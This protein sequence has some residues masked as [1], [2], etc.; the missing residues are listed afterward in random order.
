MMGFLRAPMPG[1]R[2]S[3]VLFV[4][5]AAAHAYS[6]RTLYGQA[7][8][9]PEAAVVRVAEGLAQRGHRVVVAQSARHWP[10]RSAGGVQYVPFRY[11]EGAPRVGADAVVVVR[12]HKVLKRLRRAHPAARFL[13]W[14]HESPGRSARDLGRAASGAGAAVVT[15]SDHHR[16]AVRSFVEASGRGPLTS[17]LARL[18]SPV[19][20]ALAPDR[21]HVDPDK[22][23]AAALPREAMGPVLA[24][25]AHVRRQRP[26]ARLFVT[27]SGGDGR[28]RAPLPE[29]VV[30]LGALPHRAV[31]RHLREAFCAFYPEACADDASGLRFAEANA[32]GT[33]ALAHSAGPA[34]EALGERIADR[35]QLLDARD[36]EAAAHRLA[37]WW[38]SGRP[39]V[40]VQPPFRL[41]RVLDGWER[42]LGVAARG[43]RRAAVAGVAA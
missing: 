30:A 39:A 33:P 43:P 4:D 11:K 15:V 37:R 12:Q 41:S 7:L 40:S 24:A 17:P 5:P 19:D 18:H 27:A 9:A 35:G 26:T 1:A 25:F 10:E 13:L 29:G 32:V 2:G 38:E 14:L 23:V 34:P 36:P 28:E 21:T 6:D 42:A 20:D 22:L 8:G 31:L 16:A 3:V